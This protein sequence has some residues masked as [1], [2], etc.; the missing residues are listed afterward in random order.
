MAIKKIDGQK[1][2]C[3]AKVKASEAET[4]GIDVAWTFDFTGCPEA[5]KLHLAGRSLVID[6]QTIWRHATPAERKSL[7]KKTFLVKDLLEGRKRKPKAPPTVKDVLGELG[8]MSE[9]DVETVM[10]E[11]GFVKAK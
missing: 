7:I 1:V 8:Q 6:V 10:K 9:K 3:M 5:G 2:F 4:V 11:H